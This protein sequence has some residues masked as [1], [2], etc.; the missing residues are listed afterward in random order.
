VT[1]VAVPAPV[2]SPSAPASA[3]RVS[4]PLYVAC[5]VTWGSG[6]VHLVAAVDHYGES[7]LFAALFVL[8]AVLQLVAGY[9]ICRRPS[10]RVFA[11]S[12]VLSLGIAAVWLA[13]R[14]VGLPIGPEHWQP[15]EIGAL[16]VI[17]TADEL[18]LVPLI[19]AHLGRLPRV[20]AT[21]TGVLGV[22][23]AAV[24]ALGFMLGHAH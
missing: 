24:S 1:D 17:C 16:D 4:D 14:T 10:P 12:I 5:G 23:L 8:S 2:T 18:V 21:G 20:L 3:P 9:A 13:S 15:E 11:A 7:R 19:A 22:A 6:L